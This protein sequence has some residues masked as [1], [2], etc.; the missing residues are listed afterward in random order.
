MFDNRFRQ[1]RS[2]LDYIGSLA[3]SADLF[4]STVRIGSQSRYQVVNTLDNQTEA[5]LKVETGPVKHALV[6]GVEFAREV[7]T[8]TNYQGLVLRA[9]WRFRSGN[10][11]T[12][13]LYLPCTYL[14]F[15]NTPY[16]NTNPTRIAVDTKSGYLIETANYQDVVIVNGGVRF[17]DYNITSRTETLS[18][19]AQNHSGL[20]NW[21]AGL[22]FKP[23][24]NVSAYAAY[25]TSAK[26]VGAELDGGAANYGGLNAAAQIFAPQLNKAAEIGRNGSCSTGICSRQPPSSRPM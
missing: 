1:S 11:V 8:R 14:P 10:S 21:N 24:P 2:V 18:T 23:L 20:F 7:V 4:A 16:R 6:A 3:G 9:E 19:L 17:D 26:P 12:C 5:T 25:A 15:L 13:N 22:V